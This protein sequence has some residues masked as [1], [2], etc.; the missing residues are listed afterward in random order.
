MYRHIQSP[1]MFASGHQAFAS[2]CGPRSRGLAA[3]FHRADNSEGN[4]VHGENEVHTEACIRAW[5]FT[6]DACPALRRPRPCYAMLPAW[7]PGLLQPFIE[8]AAQNARN[9]RL[10]VR[11][12][13]GVMKPVTAQAEI[14]GCCVHQHP[15]P[16]RDSPPRRAPVPLPILYRQ[17][18][19]SLTPQVRPSQPLCPTAL[20]RWQPDQRGHGVGEVRR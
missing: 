1:I 19:L 11:D 16:S 13:T 14:D 2:R 3:I 8:R 6:A 7:V 18:A 17:G 10:P 15:S 9:R 5:T 4:F 12:Q 20:R